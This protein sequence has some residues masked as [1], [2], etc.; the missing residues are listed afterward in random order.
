[1]QLK[2]NVRLVHFPQNKHWSD[3]IWGVCNISSV[4]IFKYISRDLGIVEPGEC[5]WETGVLGSGS[6]SVIYCVKVKSSGW[7]PS[8][9]QNGPVANA[10]DCLGL[11]RVMHIKAKIT[12]NLWLLLMLLENMTGVNHTGLRSLGL[13]T[14]TTLCLLLWGYRGVT[15]SLCNKRDFAFYF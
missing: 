6:G 7:K 4:I 3:S 8:S 15:G 13:D 1:M 12:I 5:F 11:T 14:N 2:I 10:Q 9:L